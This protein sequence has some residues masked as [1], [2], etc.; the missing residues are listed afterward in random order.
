MPL[1]TTKASSL[2]PVA[3]QKAQRVADATQWRQPERILASKTH[4]LGA[5]TLSI[6]RQESKLR[7]QNVVLRVY[8]YHYGLQQARL[9]KVDTDTSRL[10]ASQVLESVHLPLNQVE[11]DYASALLQTQPRII[12]RLRAEQ[13]DRGEAAFKSLTELDVKASIFEPIDPTHVCYQHRCV[14]MSL[15]DSTHTVF[16]IE[17]IINLQSGQVNLLARP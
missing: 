10:L 14:L 2:D 12:A 16:S 3:R 9:L 6:E 5:Q 7:Q 17:P 15:F 4:P 8:Q 11:K 1:S 13:S